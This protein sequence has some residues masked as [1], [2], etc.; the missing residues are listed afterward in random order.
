MEENRKLMEIT[1]QSAEITKSSATVLSDIRDTVEENG[2]SLKAA[3]NMGESLLKGSENVEQMTDEMDKQMA[4]YI[5]KATATVTAMKDRRKKVTQIF[6]LVKSGFTKMEAMLDKKSVDSIPFKLQQRRDKYA[7]YK[8]EMQRRAEEER[9]RQARIEAQKTQVTIDAKAM[10]ADIITIA[11][12]EAIDKLNGIFNG[13]TLDNKDTARESLETMPATISIVQCIAKSADKDDNSA[14]SVSIRAALRI[15]YDEL[16]A[17]TIRQLRNEAFKEDSKKLA[18]QYAETVG[19]YKQE[20]LDRFDSKIAELEEKKRI[21]EEQRRA[22]E[23]RRRAEEERRKAEEEARRKAEEAKKIADEEQ[24]R[25]AEEE[26]R[27]AAQEAA[28]K[29]EAER[30]AREEAEKAEAERKAKEEEMRRIEEEQKKEQ[31]R[32]LEEERKC[33]E[34]QMRIENAQAQSRSLFEQAPAVTAM[35]KVKVSHHIEVAAPEAFVDI[36]QMWWAHEG[37]KMS[38]DDLSKK[39]SFMVKACEKLYDKQDIAVESAYVKYVED[40]QA[41]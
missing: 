27:K 36:I 24:R 23:E 33:R 18:A 20:L 30:K 39:L 22:E 13:I 40:I 4:D 8:L 15:S 16:D 19:T 6:D 26:A 28:A 25:K 11:S 1:A 31:Q 17:N 9:K 34:E 3:I 35:P 10:M 21:E 29:T 14:L 7:A 12:N 41:K 38:V 37:S 2:K 32:R 5:K